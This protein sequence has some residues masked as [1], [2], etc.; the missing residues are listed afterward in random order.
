LDD[1]LTVWHEAG[2]AVAAYALGRRVGFVTAVPGERWSG[3]C[4]SWAE[5]VRDDRPASTGAP[6]VT[7]AAGWQRRLAGDVVFSLAGGV[8]EELFVPRGTSPVRLPES[9]SEQAQDRITELAGYAATA[10]ELAEAARSVDAPSESDAERVAALAFEAHHGDV[11]RSATWVAWLTEET[12]A[13]LLLHEPAVR[14]VAAELAR[15]GTIGE[16]AAAAALRRTEVSR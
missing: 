15:H 9:V 13:L 4:R 16:Q 1:E 11:H 6:L 5:L 10:E 8:A 7:W 14:R 2:H 12:R 3:M